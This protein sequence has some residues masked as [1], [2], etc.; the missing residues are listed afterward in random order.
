MPSS[1]SQ[2]SHRAQVA[3]PEQQPRLIPQIRATLPYRST[4]RHYLSTWTFMFIG[5]LPMA[6][7]AE[8][9]SWQITMSGGGAMFLLISLGL[10]LFR[11]YLRQWKI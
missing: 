5:S 2:G 1:P 11:P 9:F 8:S 7:V 6:M 4:G 10:E 3:G